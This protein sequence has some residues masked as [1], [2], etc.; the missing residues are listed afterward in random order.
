MRIREHYDVIQFRELDTDGSKQNLH[1]TALLYLCIGSKFPV[2]LVATWWTQREMH[3]ID[4][5][6]L[7]HE[8]YQLLSSVLD[9]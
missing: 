5:I 9:T 7:L 3:T 2:D 6:F 1:Y 8:Q 4:V